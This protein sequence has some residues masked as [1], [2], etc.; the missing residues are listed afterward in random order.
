MTLD[1]WGFGSGEAISKLR[2]L[3]VFWARIPEARLEKIF[4]GDSVDRI[5][6]SRRGFNWE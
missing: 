3:G 4:L 1:N 5:L 2:V 6:G